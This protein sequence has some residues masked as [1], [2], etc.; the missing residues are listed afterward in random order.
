MIKIDIDS[1]RLIRILVTEVLQCYGTNAGQL[2]DWYAF[3]NLIKV[4]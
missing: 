1:D 4:C 2:T 3:A